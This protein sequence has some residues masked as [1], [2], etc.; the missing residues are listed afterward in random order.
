MT[1]NSYHR[2]PTADVR[3]KREPDSLNAATKDIENGDD[4]DSNSSEPRHS[5]RVKK[6]IAGFF[7]M[8]LA[9][10]ALNTCGRG[11]LRRYGSTLSRAKLPSHFTLPSGDKI[12]SVALGMYRNLL[13]H[14][15]LLVV[16]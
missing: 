12:P 3:V 15:R 16:Y 9:L 14:M 13:Q 8:L 6:F 4:L 2:L 5:S 1:S 11:G 10:A 7:I